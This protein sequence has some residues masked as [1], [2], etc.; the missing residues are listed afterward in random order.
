MGQ[1]VWARE[2]TLAVCFRG[3]WKVLTPVEETK[4]RV[5]NIDESSGGTVAIGILPTLAPFML[6]STLLALSEEFPE[7]I[8]EVLPFNEDNLNIERLCSDEFYVAVHK[9]SPWA[10]LDM[11]PI[12]A[13]VNADS[14]P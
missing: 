12:D 5:S 14:D 7:A 8:V 13:L 9:D 3:L 11:I 2:F 6:P 4:H 1:R 10:E